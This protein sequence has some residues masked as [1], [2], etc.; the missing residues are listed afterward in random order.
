MNKLRI[1]LLHLAPVLGDIDH[2]RRLVELAVAAAA[3]E[4]AD[5]AITPELCICGYLFVDKIGT[6]WI[7]PQPDPWMDRFRAQVKQRSMTVFLSHPDRDPQTGNLYN[8]V[9]VINPTGEI[10]GQ[11][12]KVKTLRGPESWSTA[13][14]QCDTVDCDGLQVGIL[15]CA[16]SYKN[17][18]PQL[19]KE[20]G[21]ELLVSPASWSP[22]GCGPDGEWEQRT[23][24]TGLPIIV[25]NRS[26]MESDDL[27]FRG[28]ESIVAQNGNRLL[29]TTSDCSVVLTFDWDLDTMTTLSQDFTRTYL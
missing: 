18:I 29:S 28:A 4:G 14:T 1:S 22:G 2:N 3:K 26:G 23:L 19:L 9:F 27:D 20:N 5:W 21:A 15:V 6:D 24:D 11:H 25:C 17:D 12:S 16:D 7:Q 13:G 10:I 8:T